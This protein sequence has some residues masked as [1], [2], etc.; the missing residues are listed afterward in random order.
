MEPLFILVKYL[1]VGWF[2]LAQLVSPAVQVVPEISYVNNIS[3]LQETPETLQAKQTPVPAETQ[4]AEP[5]AAREGLVLP[6]PAG[7]YR[8]TDNFGPRCTGI[9]GASK[10]HRGID[11]GADYGTPIYAI[12]DGTIIKVVD[13][14]LGG[15]GGTVVLQTVIDGKNVAFYYHH[16]EISSKFVQ[17]GQT[18]KAG[19]QISEVSS[20]GVSSGANLH[21]EVWAGGYPNGAQVDPEP[22]FA[23]IGLPVIETATA[24]TV[25]EK[26][27]CLDGTNAPEGPNNY[28]DTTSS[29]V[30]DG[31][32]SSSGAPAA[33][34]TTTPTPTPTTP[35]PTP[36]TPT[37]T[38]SPTPTPTPTK[39]VTPTP[40]PS[41][42]EAASTPTVSPTP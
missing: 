26:T 14:F 41:P 5:V 22:Y 33:P 19:D 8:F 16:M 17:P 31:N 36:T 28:Y 6:L 25:T 15:R 35:T 12:A 38:P 37:P 20:T 3:A 32:S 24:N 13:G 29:M 10:Y 1:V 7:S 27:Y 2:S 11:L 42:S 40:T 30:T 18:V 39:T 9:N 23:S 34:P 4:P 21:L